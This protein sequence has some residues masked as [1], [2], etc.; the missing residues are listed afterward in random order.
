MQLM[1]ANK[2]KLGWEITISLVLK[3]IIIYLLWL[4]FFSQPLD[5]HLTGPDVGEAL[6][7]AASPDAAAQ[8]ADDAAA[9][10]LIQQRAAEPGLEQ[11]PVQ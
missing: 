9:Q 6:F 5:D 7:G 10:I 4:A 1:I 3:L 8:R 2:H 11:A